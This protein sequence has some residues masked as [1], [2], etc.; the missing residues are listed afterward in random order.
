MKIYN[1]RTIESFFK[2]I[3]EAEKAETRKRDRAFKSRSKNRNP[4][5]MTGYGSISMNRKG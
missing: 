5:S 4:K 1:K 3:D 2:Y